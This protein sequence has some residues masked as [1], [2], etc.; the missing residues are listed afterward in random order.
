MSTCEENAAS[1][2]N[3]SSVLFQPPPLTVPYLV[4]PVLAS[5]QGKLKMRRFCVTPLPGVTFPEQVE[6]LAQ[7]HHALKEKLGVCPAAC[8]WCTCVCVCVCVCV[9]VHIV[10]TWDFLI[11]LWVK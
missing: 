6:H 4:C 8:Y 5:G 10:S 3:P 2:L 9:Y 1:L 7:F 11:S